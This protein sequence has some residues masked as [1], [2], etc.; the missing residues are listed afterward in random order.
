L[1][2]NGS[3]AFARSFTDPLSNLV[4][5]SSLN[6]GRHIQQIQ[7]KDL[8][9]ESL[10]AF[11]HEATHH[12]CARSPVGLAEMLLF[13]RARRA[14]LRYSQQTR[15]AGTED[16]IEQ[17]HKR[18]DA[19]WT[20]LDAVARY[21]FSQGL[22]RPLSEGLAL[23]AEHDASV[24][25]AETISVPAL[26]GSALYA[27]GLALKSDRPFSKFPLVLAGSRLTK[28]HI[29]RKA[30]LL[31]QP[32]DCRDGG[33][34]PGYLGLKMAWRANLLHDKCAAF[35]DTDF[36]LQF[37]RSFFFDDWGL[38]ACL[39]DET[40]S[41]AGALDPIGRRLQERLNALAVAPSRV[42]EAERFERTAKAARPRF[43]L[44]TE[45]VETGVIYDD[46]C[47]SVELEELGKKRLETAFRE[48]FGSWPT[49]LLERALIAHDLE[50][51]GLANTMTLAH[52]ELHGCRR[53]DRLVFTGNDMPDFSSPAPATMPEGWD[54]P[55][56]L[57]AIASLVPAGLFLVMARGEEPPTA[58]SLGAPVDTAW[59]EK[60]MA[61]MSE[62]AAIADETRELLDGVLKDES[63]ELIQNH[64]RT[65][66]ARMV[67]QIYIPRALAHV[68]EDLISKV[69][70]LGREDGLL[71]L[72]GMDLPALDDCAALSLA[73]PLKMNPSAVHSWSG[74]DMLSTARKLNEIL[75]PTLGFEPFLV[76]DDKLLAAFI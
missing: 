20:V 38:V 60:R 76:V 36:F 24:G 30:D 28:T 51:L 22:M 55:V 39:L 21:E 37:A 47:G 8:P 6:V 26:L 75:E 62:R 42:M 50:M 73:A 15:A 65:Q 13:F 67:P 64:V 14:A 33:Y 40:R 35:F 49:E 66:L 9:P 1:S 63:F 52:G 23:F 34:L 69:Q 44:R 7:D 12:W 43:D 5:L 41:D 53:G 70:T 59:L 72:P 18:R 32:L 10:P 11:M 25:F 57:D 3:S 68:P 17:F 4:F 48:L 46:V 16:A 31:V 27:Q 19:E 56:K 29:R 71:P 2:D 54:G 61:T 45:L 74:G 58:H